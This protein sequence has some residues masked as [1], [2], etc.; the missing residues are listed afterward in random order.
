[1]V[2]ILHELFQERE[3]LKRRKELEEAKKQ[4]CCLSHVALGCICIIK[5]CSNQYHDIGEI[6]FPSIMSHVPKDIESDRCACVTQLVHFD[7]VISRY[8]IETVIL[9]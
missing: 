8:R 2:R 6:S 3:A 1:M 9:I 5:W 4:G 7:L